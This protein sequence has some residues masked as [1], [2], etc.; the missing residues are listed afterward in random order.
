MDQP[1]KRSW[2]GRHWWWFVPTVVLAPIACCGGFVVLIVSLVFGMIKSSDA[3]TQSLAMVQ[4]D[5]RAQAVL[6]TPIEPGFFVTGNINVSGA[7]GNADIAYSLTGPQGKATLYVQATKSV[8]QWT[9]HTL[10]LEPA[11]GPRLDLLEQAEAP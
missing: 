11:Q 8:G 4:A 6:G 3:Y 5:P 1:A 9:F 2:F 10:A 7:S